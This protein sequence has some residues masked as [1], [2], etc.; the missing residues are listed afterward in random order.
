MIFNKKAE[1]QSDFCNKNE[2]FQIEETISKYIANKERKSCCKEK[3]FEIFEKKCVKS[4]KFLPTSAKISKLFLL[5]F[6][7]T[8]PR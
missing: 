7:C 1:R 4:C 8:R 2:F 6:Y 5:H 3:S